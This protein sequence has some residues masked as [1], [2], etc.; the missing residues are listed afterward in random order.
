MEFTGPYFHNGSHQ[1]YA[2]SA[3]FPGAGNLGNGIGNINLSQTGQT[4]VVAFLKALSDDRVRFQQ[5]PFDHPSLCVSNGQALD[6]WALVLEVGKSGLGVPLQ[7]FQE[8][9]TGIG[10][11][12]TRANTM[13]TS[14]TP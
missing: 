2:R 11:D 4:A 5:A 9:L 14:C 3:D 8:L 6:K 10:N 13:T 12:G 1:F 7:T